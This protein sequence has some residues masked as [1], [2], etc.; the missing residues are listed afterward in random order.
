MGYPCPYEHTCKSLLHPSSCSSPQHA[1]ALLKQDP[2]SDR[3]QHHKP[4]LPSHQRVASHILH[5]TSH[6]LLLLLLAGSVRG[7]K[8][9]L[10]LELRLMLRLR[11]RLGPRLLLLLLLCAVAAGCSCC[12]QCVLTHHTHQGV[13]VN[14]QG[15]AADKRELLRDSNHSL[16]SACGSGLMMCCCCCPREHADQLPASMQDGADTESMCGTFP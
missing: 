2:S 15:V 16:I 14:I 11:L 8:L 1:Q 4:R 5:V 3:G 13:D 9:L 12:C 7:R 6:L 10:L